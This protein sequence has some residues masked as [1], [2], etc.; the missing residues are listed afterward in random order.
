MFGRFFWKSD[1]KMVVSDS[2]VPE[3][4]FEA[5]LIPEVA[6]ELTEHV[7]VFCRCLTELLG[8]IVFNPRNLI[9]YKKTNH[10]F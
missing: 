10:F 1:S 3:L 8:E 2:L 5:E 6:L 9:A 4:M 7:I